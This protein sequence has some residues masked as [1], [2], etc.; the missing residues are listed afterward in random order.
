MPVFVN[1]FN[2]YFTLVNIFFFN[3]LLS[4][5]ARTF[6]YRKCHSIKYRVISSLI[7]QRKRRISVCQKGCNNKKKRKYSGS[8]CMLWLHQMWFKKKRWKMH[9]RVWN[10][11]S[12]VAMVT[13]SQER[14]SWQSNLVKIINVGVSLCLIY[15]R[16]CS[17]QRADGAR[18]SFIS[19]D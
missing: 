15:V 7:N 11:T 16:A 14:A 5:M 1:K 4:V 3:E 6:K 19:A 9:S 10:A 8:V 17:C 2:H 13:V 12:G 18:Q